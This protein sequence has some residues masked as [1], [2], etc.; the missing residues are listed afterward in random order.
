[1]E[2]N[3]G[4]RNKSQMNTDSELIKKAGNGTSSLTK[5]LLEMVV[6]L[7]LSPL[8]TSRQQTLS[9][10]LK[11]GGCIYGIHSQG[12]K[13]LKKKQNSR[14]CFVFFS[15]CFISGSLPFSF[16]LTFFSFQHIHLFSFLSFLF[17]LYQATSHNN[18]N[19]SGG[20]KIEYKVV[21]YSRV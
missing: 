4:P 9:A 20:R 11:M 2:W 12:E 18:R 21:I 7:C 13:K 3:L 5:L 6:E 19:C 14:Q 10:T 17:V 16:H 15:T 8:F 1:M